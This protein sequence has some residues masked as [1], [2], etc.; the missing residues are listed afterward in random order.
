MDENTFVNK[1]AERTN[2]LGKSLLY[3][4]YS[5]NKEP[6]KGRTML[7]K[8]MFLVAKFI[9]EVWELAEFIPY[10]HGAYSEDIEVLM[11]EFKSYE[12]LK[13]DYGNIYLTDFGEKATKK[14]TESLSKEEKEAICEFK[15]FMNKMSLDEVLV[16]SY[17]SYKF[18]AKDSAILPRVLSNR[19]R[20][21][22][23]L[24]KKGIINLEKAMFLSGLS[25]KEF[26]KLVKEK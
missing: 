6:I 19:L 17:F 18:F 3:L 26:F 25:G 1:I 5:N 23:N 11:N 14:I 20:V 24:Y 15:N 21:S 9:S 16:Y 4:I 7:Q 8:E 13:E 2:K 12:V 22:I 10:N